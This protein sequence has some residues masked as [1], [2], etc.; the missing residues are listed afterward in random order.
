MIAIGRPVEGISINGLEFRDYEDSY[1]I[2]NILK[3]DVN[4]HI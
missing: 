2:T 1:R 3:V 4:E